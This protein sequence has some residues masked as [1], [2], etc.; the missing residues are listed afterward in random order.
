M[1]VSLRWKEY[2]NGSKQAYLDIYVKG[3]KRKR[4]FLPIRISKNDTEKKSKKLKA[5]AIRTRR[6]SEIIDN[7]YGLLSE[8]KLKSC[9]IKYYQIF[10]D[11]YNKAGKRKYRYAYEWF[12]NYLKHIHKIK[13]IKPSTLKKEYSQTAGRLPFNEIDSKLIQGYSDYLT[14]VNSSLSGET[15]KSGQIDHPFPF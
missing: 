9:F 12:L 6:H 11:S 14:G 15:A 2:K 4:E 5:A 13:D 8:E 1:T 10:L 7:Q 3:Q